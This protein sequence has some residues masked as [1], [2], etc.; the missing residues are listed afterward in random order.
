M[1]SYGYGSI[2][3]NTIF[4][5]MNIHLPAILMFTRGIGFWP[6]PKSVQ[7]FPVGSIDLW[8]MFI[9]A[10]D[11]VN[12][13]K[14]QSPISHFHLVGGFNPSEK[15]DFVSWDDSSQYMEVIK[16]MF[17]SPPTRNGTDKNSPCN[18]PL[19]RGMIWES[20]KWQSVGFND[21]FG[22]RY[23]SSKSHKVGPPNDSK[24][25]E[26]NSNNYGLWYL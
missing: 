23:K 6:I 18:D 1:I 7:W 14:P 11:R 15:Y 4:S 8:N 2:P 21:E 25:G 24:V 19:L 20:A 10:I 5:G 26:H 9:L 3:I 12:S 22:G 17:Q 13:S 16:F